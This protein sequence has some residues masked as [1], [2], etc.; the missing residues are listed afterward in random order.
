MKIK[1]SMKQ[2]SLLG[3]GLLISLYCTLTIADNYPTKPIKA[4]V[5]FAPGSATDQIGRAFA[6]KMGEALGQPVIVENRPG[7][8]G[9]IGADVV[10]KSPADGYTLLFGTNSTNAALKS[11]AKNLP[12]NQDTAFT[13]I[14]YFGSV[15][16][17]I[18]V[19]N[20]LPVK[21]L[22]GFVTL[23]KSDPGKVTFAYAS[24]SQRVSSEMLASVAGI[25]MT[26]VSYK[27]G[28][29]AMTDL[30]GGQVNMFSS[31]FAVSLP[32][33]QAGKIHG[34]AVTS[35]KRSPAIPQLP[36]VNEAL[37]IKN[38]E[39]IAFFAAFGPANMPKDIVLKLNNAI[40]E[41]AKS[42]DLV[43]RFSAMGFETQPGSPEALDKKIKLETAKWAKAIKEAG[44]EPE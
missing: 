1:Y 16:L 3:M 20:D 8:S 40:N 26:G 17:I 29:N 14:G 35:L 38:Y 19:N 6:A 28:P 39:L 24:A 15:P 18:A 25:K 32:Q 34:L 36:T 43:E 2:L 5:P 21:S 44:M 31:D 37:G 30:I 27:S 42:R 13:P 22:N 33:V 41:A 11:L 23:A 9:M 12:Y 7:A 10:A 4:I